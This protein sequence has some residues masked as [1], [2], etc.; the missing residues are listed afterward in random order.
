MNLL[1]KH[2]LVGALL[3]LPERNLPCGAGFGA[4]Y[5]GWLYQQPISNALLSLEQ[6][7]MAFFIRLLR[8]IMCACMYVNPYAHTIDP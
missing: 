4:Q 6:V 3:A 2:R 8:E 7:Q 5:L 1:N